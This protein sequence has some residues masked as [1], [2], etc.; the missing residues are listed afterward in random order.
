MKRVHFYRQM[1]I[2]IDRLVIHTD[3]KKISPLQGI[4]LFFRYTG[5]IFLVKSTILH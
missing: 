5:Y 2:H 1:N 3:I 4:Q